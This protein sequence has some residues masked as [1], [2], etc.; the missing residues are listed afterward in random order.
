MNNSSSD[1]I[2]KEDAR[3]AAAALAYWFMYKGGKEDFIK[4][5]DH[6]STNVSVS[7]NGRMIQLAFS[8][9]VSDS[10]ALKNFIERGRSA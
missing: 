7:D 2:N 6:K 10:L 4:Y 5:A 1:N 3:A 8:M 9:S